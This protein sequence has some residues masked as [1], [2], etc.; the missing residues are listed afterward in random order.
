MRMRLTFPLA[1]AASLACL[2]PP[3]AKSQTDTSLKLSTGVPQ[4]AAEFRAGVNDWQ[5]RSVE[6]ASSHFGAAVNADPNF[7]LARVMHGYVGNFA[8]ELTTAQGLAEVNRGVAD[9]AAR[10]N[11]NEILLAV[12]Y[13]ETFK[14]N[15]RAAAEIFDAAAHLMPGD[16]LV[17]S[18]A[19]GAGSNLNDPVPLLR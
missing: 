19:I 18:N 16:R 6:P 8:G 17:A 15:P 3:A 11:T 13:R 9:A 10:G 14:N 1:V 4:A 7:G 5:N 12:A 2:T